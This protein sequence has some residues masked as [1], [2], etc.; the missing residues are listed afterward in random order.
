MPGI[1]AQGGSL[2]AISEAALTPDCGLL[3]NASRAIIYA[4]ED[5]TF[6]EEAAAIAQQYAFEMKL[7]LEALSK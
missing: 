6:A 5:E 1:G 3:V 4:S 2:K 7:Y